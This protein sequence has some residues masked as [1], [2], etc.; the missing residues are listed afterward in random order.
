MKKLCI[1]ISVCLIILLCGCNGYKEIDRGYIVTAIGFKDKNGT[2][3]IFI[4]VLYSS[5]VTDEKN[6]RTILTASGPDETQAYKNLESALVKPLY[7]EQLG[8]VVFEKTTDFNIGFLKEIANINLGVYIV[9]T[10]NIINLFENATPNGVLGYDVISLIKTQQKEGFKKA[11]NQL[12]KS[13][14]YNFD[15]PYVNFVDGNLILKQM[16]NTK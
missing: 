7:F 15:I 1:L 3:D 10:D 8:T 5:D 11:T 9:K 6:K 12:Y 14:S 4:E 2:T 13:Q 16:E